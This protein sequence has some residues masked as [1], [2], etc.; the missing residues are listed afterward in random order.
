M[1]YVRV[2]DVSGQA[3]GF[4]EFL[5]NSYFGGFC[6]WQLEEAS[7]QKLNSIVSYL[8][9]CS[10]DQITRYYAP[11]VNH[12]VIIETARLQV[13]V[14]DLTNIATISSNCF[15]SGAD[16]R[17]LRV[18][19]APCNF[20]E[21]LRSISNI[22]L[23]FI[24]MPKINFAVV[25]GSAQIAGHNVAIPALGLLNKITDSVNIQGN[26]NLTADDIINRN[27]TFVEEIHK[28][29]GHGFEIFAVASNHQGTFSAS[30]CK[31]SR[32]ENAIIIIWNSKECRHRCE[33][34]CHKLTVIHFAFSNND[35]FLLSFL[36]IENFRLASE[37]KYSKVHSCIIWYCAWTPDDKCFL[38]FWRFD[39]NDVEL[40]AERKHLN[41]VTAVSAKGRILVKY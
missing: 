20:V 22:I 1:L 8:L 15:V 4:F 23:H 28:L 27:G 35:S 13:H 30:A 39:E 7:L 24:H 32:S 21:M 5:L 29:C 36:L 26:E 6:S 34:Q 10:F 37:Q 38:C 9:S 25:S 33:L 2:G 16:E 11:S 40:V 41:A 3:V 12:G 18:F 14:S 17:I 19:A 31:A